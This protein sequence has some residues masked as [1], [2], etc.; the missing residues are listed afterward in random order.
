[1]VRIETY[2]A[3]TLEIFYETFKKIAPV[4]VL[5]KITDPKLLPPG[6][7]KNVMTSPW[8]PQ[9]A[10]LSE[11]HNNALNSIKWILSV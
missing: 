11:F 10:I 9:V 6:L 7:P 1:M 5:L 3:A 8:L 4:R 2:P